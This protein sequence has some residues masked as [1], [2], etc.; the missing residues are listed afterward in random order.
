MTVY[1]LNLDGLVGPTHCFGGLAAGNKASIVNALKPSNPK[2]AAL[3]GIK[4]MRLMHSL[5]LQQGLLLPQ[6]RPNL[7]LLHQLGFHGTPKQQ[8]QEAF[9]KAPELLNAFFSASSMWAANT[10]TVAASLDTDNHK[11]HFTPANLITHLHRQQEVLF[12]QKLL[13]LIFSD[14]NYFEHH[15]ALPCSTTTADEGAANHSRMAQRHA[16]AGLN[17]FV[18]GKKALGSKAPAPIQFPAR[19]TREACESIA[20]SHLLDPSKTIF[21]QQNPQAIDLGVFHNDVICVANESVLLVHEQAFYQQHQVIQELRRKADFD[22]RLI[23]IPQEAL[24]IEEAVHSYLFN[25]QIVTLPKEKGMVLIAPIEAQEQARAKACIDA[26][27]EQASNPIQSV[28]FFDL[29]QSMRN[30]GGP[31]C[32]RLRVPLSAKELKAMHP[33]FL[34]NEERL[35]QLELWVMK[36]YRTHL[37]ERD[38]ADPHF[39]DE[40]FTA[41]DELTQL[42]QLKSIYPFQFE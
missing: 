22:L 13:Q 35:N 26:I 31:A 9:K 4:K 28:H 33:S 6:Q 34:V 3:Q 42:L 32:L 18:Y 41:L 2:A 40:I 7:K 19:Q 15:Q 17:L 29:R 23:E 14:P 25:S 8:V 27:V 24:S 11:V 30:G 38:F 36:H 37:E 10:A 20:R 21:A 12:S 1:E 5:G 16:Q 39:I